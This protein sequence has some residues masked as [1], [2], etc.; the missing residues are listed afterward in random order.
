M[1]AVAGVVTRLALGTGSALAAVV[2]VI[3]PVTA[4]LFVVVTLGA[5]LLLHELRRRFLVVT[6]DGRSMEPTYR[7]GQRV[8]VRRLPATVW[9]R[10]VRAGEVVVFR[11]PHVPQQ[12][13]DPD[14]RP[15]PDDRILLKR[16]A[17]GPGDPVPRAAVAALRDVPERRVPPAN[18]VVLGDNPSISYDSREYGYVPADLLVGVAVRTLA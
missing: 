12:V 9:R 1:R 10:S 5:L 8:L 17:A 4:R 18:F 14:E 6:V 2:P 11:A 13:D 16:L 15:L 3:T 7:A